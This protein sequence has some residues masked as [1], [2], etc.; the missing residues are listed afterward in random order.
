MSEPKNFSKKY[1]IDAGCS[2][3]YKSST[4]IKGLKA[5]LDE[6]FFKMAKNGFSQCRQLYILWSPPLDHFLRD[7]ADIFGYG[8]VPGETD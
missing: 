3:H 5:S 6:D 7:L 4:K 8:E 1:I 2:R